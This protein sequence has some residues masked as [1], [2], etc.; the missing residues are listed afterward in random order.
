MNWYNVQITVT[1][2][3]K[4]LEVVAYEYGYVEQAVLNKVNLHIYSSKDNT[5]HQVHQSLPTQ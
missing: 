2:L 5:A 3:K 1:N 4:P